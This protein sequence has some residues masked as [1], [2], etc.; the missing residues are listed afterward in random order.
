MVLNEDYMLHTENMKQILKIE[1][2]Y[3][4][5][6][7]NIDEI[8][9]SLDWYRRDDRPVQADL[10]DWNVS[11]YFPDLCNQVNVLYPN[12]KIQDLWVASYGRGDYA[13]THD[14]SDFDWSFVW[15]LDACVS[16]NPISFPNLEKPWLP[17]ERVYPKV[18]NLHV[19]DANRK[20]YVC[21][22]TCHNHNRVVVSGNLKRKPDEPTINNP[23]I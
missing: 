3:V 9:D 15:Y 10:T 11:Q 5:P 14:H 6:P 7:V 12:H 21:P 19:F 8:L 17:D 22:H 4:K 16:C 1:T 20:H 2:F 18:G 23:F 13:E